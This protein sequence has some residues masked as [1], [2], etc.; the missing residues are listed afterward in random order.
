M[1]IKISVTPQDI[2]E[3]IQGRCEQCAGALALNRVLTNAAGIPI[4]SRVGAGTFT[5]FHDTG[6]EAI[7]IA[8]LRSPKKLDSFAYNFDYCKA[9]VKPITFTIEV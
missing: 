9:A 7:H 6:D 4:I 2:R 1:R 5:I 3:G 8:T